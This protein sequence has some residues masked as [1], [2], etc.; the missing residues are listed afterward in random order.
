MNEHYRRIA[1]DAG[2]VLWGDEDWK[3]EGGI[4]DWANEYDYELNQYSELLVK[5]CSAIIQNFVDQRIPASE[6]PRLLR[7][8]FSGE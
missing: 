2:F 5:E 8:H 1:N 6:Y 7:E 4:V 3:P